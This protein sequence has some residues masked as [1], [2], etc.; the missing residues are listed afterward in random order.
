MKY[1]TVASCPWDIILGLF[2]IMNGDN[3][4]TMLNQTQSY[5]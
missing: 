2:M 3:L 5:Q 1:T 4:E